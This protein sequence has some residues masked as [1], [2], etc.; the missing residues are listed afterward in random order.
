MTLPTVT[1]PKYTTKL[2]STDEL[3][4]YRPFIVKEEKVL[5]I[6]L[7][8]GEYEQISRALK[9]IVKACTFD[10]LDVESLPIFDLCYL[11][12]NI[13]AKSVG[14]V[15][16]PNLTCPSCKAT[17]LVKIDLTEIKINKKPEHTTKIDLGDGL[18]IV[19]KYPV[20][21][22]KQLEGDSV[23]IQVIANCVEMI[24]Q[25]E[26]LWKLEDTSIEEI[27]NFI[28]HLTHKQFEKILQ[29]YETMPEF[30][31]EVKYKCS[32]CEKENSVVLEGIGD[33]FL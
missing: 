11:F 17:T 9:D 24:Y 4:H 7:E 2:T 21:F 27:V 32:K 26:K 20:L 10:K 33:F 8:S 12:I 30:K 15:V 13:R 16:E 23:D 28:E 31:H 14:E 22:E 3:V 1:I 19:M 25:N 6:A 29:F 18:G 5:L